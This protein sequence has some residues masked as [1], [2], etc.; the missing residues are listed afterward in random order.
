MR[1]R[2]IK[3]VF[4]Y[5]FLIL[6]L[7]VFIYSIYNIIDWYIAGKKNEKIINDINDAII[8]EEIEEE[9]V[10]EDTSLTVDFEI[11]KEKN[12]E[13]V[14]F[15]K[16]NG[17]KIEYSVVKHKD[18]FYYLT[19]SFDRSYNKYGWIFA[20]FENKFDGTDKNITLFGHNMRNGSMFGTLKNVL[21]EEWQSNED[22]HKV[23]FITEEGK[24]IYQVFSTYK[25]YKEEYFATSNFK[26]D[27]EFLTF[28][29]K[30][31]KRSNK[32]YNVEVTENDQ[33]LTLSTCHSNNN[34]RVV[35]HAKKMYE[36]E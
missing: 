8:E 21:T 9:I 12:S 23:L 7:S 5:L 11:L 32:D 20:N 30:I 15:I 10:D 25:I 3:K 33:I 27:S 1:A 36:I 31:K 26:D 22:N 6:F 29:N 19:H 24:F 13:A 17:T 34:Y 18:N 14:G 35:L 4:I 2:K 16:V 28:I